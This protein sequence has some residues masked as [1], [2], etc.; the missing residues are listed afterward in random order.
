LFCV[1]GKF[2]LH[3]HISKQSWALASLRNVICSASLY[4]SKLSSAFVVSNTGSLPADHLLLSQAN[5]L[6]TTFLR[7]V[8]P[9]DVDCLQLITSRRGDQLAS[10]PKQFGM[11]E[12]M[13]RAMLE[14]SK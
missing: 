8:L 6:T 1:A 13:L 3:G 2:W 12:N 11:T 4:I 5:Y 7:T 9:E 10:T 14:K